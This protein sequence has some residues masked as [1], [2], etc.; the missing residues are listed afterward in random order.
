MI[1]NL[2]R[3]GEGRVF[4][5]HGHATLGNAGG[6]SVLKGTF[7]PGWKWSD[8]V[9]PIAGTSSCQVRHMG[10]VLEGTMHIRMD[11]G[12]EWDI[13][14]GDVVDL[15]AG[16]DAWVTSDVALEMV[17]ISPEATRYAVTRPTDIASP[18][19]QWMT[20]VRRGY[21]AF[22]SGDVETLLGLFSKDVVQHVP[23]HG[24]LAGTYKGPEAVLGYYGKLAELTGGTFRADL[25][26]VHGDGSGHVCATHQTSATRNGAKRVARGSIVFTCIGDKVTDMLEL[27]ADLPGDDAFLA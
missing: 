23:G 6:I 9:K 26:D 22:N 24:P 3:E 11:D 21:A 25:V 16:H 18:D 20:L 5:A 4:R 10:Y 13:G 1:S 2:D 7:E 19:D 15:P 27:R 17:D 14:A 8:D 12:S